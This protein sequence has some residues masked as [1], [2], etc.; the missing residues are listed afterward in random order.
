M[1][2]QAQKVQ[3]FRW[4]SVRGQLRLEKIGMKS[5]GGALR[6]R[7]SKELGLMPRDSHDKYIAVVQKKLDEVFALAEASV[8]E[9]GQLK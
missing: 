6:P 9:T 2:T 7:L 1:V 5:S 8:A 3:Y 4:L